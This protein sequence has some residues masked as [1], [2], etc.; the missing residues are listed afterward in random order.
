MHCPNAYCEAHNDVIKPD[1]ES[2]LCAHC[3]K[4]TTAAGRKVKSDD[5]LPQGVLEIEALREMSRSES[6]VEPR[7]DEPPPHTPSDSNPGFPWPNYETP[8]PPP[9]QAQL[10]S[11]DL[12]LGT[13]PTNPREFWEQNQALI[14]KV[15]MGLAGF[16]LLIRLIG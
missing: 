4:P 3:A 2:P 8:P 12:P 5:T 7:R 6:G 1:V 9:G 11:G 15:G 10:D 13:M 14:L 16:W